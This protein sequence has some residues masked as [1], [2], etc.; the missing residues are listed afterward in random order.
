[1]I[2]AGKILVAPAVASSPSVLTLA[3]VGQALCC[4][5]AP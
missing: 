1:M 2:V 4:T 5:G 3:L